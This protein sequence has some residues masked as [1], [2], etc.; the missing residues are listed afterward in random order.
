[1]TALTTMK[2][3]FI[4][5]SVLFFAQSATAQRGA[6]RRN[7]QRVQAAKIGFIT[8]RVNLT[9]EQTERFWPVYHRYEDELRTL[10]RKAVSD[11]LDKRSDNNLS[12]A[13]S[14]R[15]ID[16]QLELQE[17][18][19]AIQRKYKDQ[20]LRVISAQQ[21]VALYDAEREFNRLLIQRVRQQRAKRQA[22]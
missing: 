11:A 18:R 9:G 13:D 15:A 20:F 3:L 7:I 12:E 19:L 10:R 14:R 17:D 16:Q 4:L 22:R 8:Q 1:M 6:G 5:L 2:H 21:L